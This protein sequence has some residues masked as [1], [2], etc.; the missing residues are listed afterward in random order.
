MSDDPTTEATGAAPRL[1]GLRLLVV[2]DDANFRYMLESLLG[3]EGAEVLLACDGREGVQAVLD[4]LADGGLPLDAVLMDVQMPVLDGYQATREIRKHFDQV[5][6]P[7][8]A[9]TGSG[10]SIDRRACLQAGMNDTVSKP[11]HLD[12]LVAC[13]LHQILHQGDFVAP[14]SSDARS[15]READMEA[16]M[17]TALERMGGNLH[18]FISVLESFQQNLA[19][20]PARLAGLLQAQTGSS[21]VQPIAEALTA[22][23]SLKALA[24]TLGLNELAARAAANEQ[25]LLKPDPE[26]HCAAVLAD[27]ELAIGRALQDSTAMLPRLRARAGSTRR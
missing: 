4:T 5:A 25:T 14:T 13:L 8:I 7:I 27:L 26:P 10:S 3:G 22:L 9:L 19:Q 6:L 15:K 24:L 23:H 12:Q 1:Q 20:L 18:I 17:Q 16:D 21:M 2:E 11:I